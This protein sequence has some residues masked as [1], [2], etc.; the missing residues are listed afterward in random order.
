MPQ[1]PSICART[2]L[3][4]LL[5]CAFGLAL[6]GWCH[7]AEP[8][9]DG[10]SSVE[11]LR[12]PLFS[13]GVTQG[14]ANHLSPAERADCA[15][16]WHAKGIT[17]AQWAFWEI[18]E[19]LY[20]AHNPETPLLPAPGTFL[21]STADKAKQCLIE[22]GALRMIFDTGKEWREGGSLNLPDKDGHAPRYGDPATTWPH[23]LIGQHFAKDNNPATLIPDAEKLSFDKFHRLRFRADIKLHRVLKS[24]PWDHHADYKAANHAIFYLAFV[25]MPTKASRVADGGKI[26]ILAP[27]IY[28]EGHSQHV[29]GTL[30]WVGLDQFGDGV[31]F[32]GA[33]PLLQPG[34][35][36]PY[37]IDVK[38]LI[39]ESFSAMTQKALA[40]GKT[41]TYRP[42]DYFLACLLVGWE[43]WGGFDTEVEFKSLSLRG[44]P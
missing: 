22:N 30:P 9:A 44:S 35:W 32:S 3:R 7:A 23:F 25:V 24:S 8:P 16:R 28:S 43:V 18:S 2:C 4:T 14:Y 19:K 37:D 41:R 13:R 33:Q 42:E 26:Y 6:L 20:F 21:W 27:A 40:Q 11:L 17:D 36:V 10:A 39:R 5:S 38:Q 29:Q 1:A 31:Y 34:S 15:S 12:D